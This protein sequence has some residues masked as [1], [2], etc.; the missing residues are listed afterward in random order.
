MAA[1]RIILALI[2]SVSLV[3]APARSANAMCL[4]TAALAGDSAEIAAPSPQHDCPCC[5]PLSKCSNANCLANCAPL[6]AVGAVTAVLFPG[7]PA[8][9]DSVADNLAFGLIALPPT[10]RKPEPG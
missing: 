4:A 2:V 10:H 6:T 5:N 1:V 7:L 9:P 8:V 3:L